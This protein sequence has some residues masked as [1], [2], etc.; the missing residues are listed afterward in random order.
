MAVKVERREGTSGQYLEC[1]QSKLGVRVVKEVDAELL[2]QKRVSV[3][4]ESA[5][6]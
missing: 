2:N 1:V 4:G 6:F 5:D 3:E